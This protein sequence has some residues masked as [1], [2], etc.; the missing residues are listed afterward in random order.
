MEVKTNSCPEA[1]GHPGGLYIYG[2]PCGWTL[3]LA[4]GRGGEEV[5][6]PCSWPPNIP[7]LA[8][9][10]EVVL[11]RTPRPPMVGAGLQPSPPTSFTTSL[12]QSVAPDVEPM[13]SQMATDRTS[14]V[15]VKAVQ[16][17]FC[18]SRHSPATRATSGVQNPCPKST[19]HNL[20]CH[21]VL[22]RSRH[23]H[24]LDYAGPPH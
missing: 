9:S 20:P 22:R 4:H 14:L 7:P 10:H 24:L 3:A 19:S 2:G 15:Y 8:G 21:K 23:E 17:R 13:A 16:N 18:D 12:A 1:P 11:V 6:S 5:A